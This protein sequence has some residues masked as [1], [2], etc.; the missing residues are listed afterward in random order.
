MTEEENRKQKV[1]RRSAMLASGKSCRWDSQGN[2]RFLG[3]LNVQQYLE[4]QARYGVKNPME[5]LKEEL[6]K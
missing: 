3:G 2:P 1:L 4:Q 5:S 6:N